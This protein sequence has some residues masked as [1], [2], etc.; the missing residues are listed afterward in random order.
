MAADGS[1]VMNVYYDRKTF[2]LTFRTGNNGSTVAT[3]TDKWGAS[4]YKKFDAAPFNTTYEGRAWQCT[5][6]N[7]YGFALQTLDIMPKFN[8]TFNLYN[9]SS[10]TLKTIYY[11]VENVGANV[12][13]NSWPNNTNNFTLLKEVQ[14]YFNYATYQEEYHEMVGFIRYSSNTAGFNSSS[15]KDFSNNKLNL[16]YLRDSFVLDFNNGED[17]TRTETVE[18]EANLGTYS[19]Y[20]P[21]VPERYEPGSVKFDGW[22]LNPQCTG[23]EYILSEHNMD[24]A[25]LI[26]YAKWTPVTHEVRFFADETTDRT[27]ANVYTPVVDGQAVPF[28]KDI[29][30]GSTIQGS[31]IPPDPTKGQ[32]IFVGWFYE[33]ANGNEQMWDFANTTV[34]GDTD[35][36]AKWSSNTLVEY[37][38]KFVTIE[39]GKE[40]EIADR[41]IGSA[42]GGNSK[43]FDAKGNNQLYDGYREGYFPTTK[44]HTIVMDLENPENNSFTFYYEKKDA[45]P[46]TVY[47][48]TTK[49]E[50]SLKPVEING[51]TYYIV[52][53]TKTVSDNKKAI[54][55]ET[56]KKVA[57]YL[58]DTYQQTLTIDPDGNNIIIFKYNKDEKNGMYV[59]HYMTENIDGE[60]IEH[61]I[62]EGRGEKGSNVDAVIK[63][64][65]NF[66]YNA[67]HKDNVLSG[68]IS[69]EEVLELY[70]YYDRN[71]YPYKV[72]YLEEGTNKPLADD[73]LVSNKVWEEYVTEKAITID[74]YTIVGD[75]TK[76]IQIRKD[77]E[78]PTVNIITF[79]YAENKA[80]LTIKKS[81]P[82]DADYSI[83]E[84]Q[85]F[86]FTVK[87]VDEL[88]NEKAKDIE[89][90]V[91]IHGAGEVKITD[92]PAGKYIVTENEDWSWRYD[93]DANSKEVTLAPGQKTGLV[94]FTNTREKI[95]WLDGDHFLVNIFDGKT[96]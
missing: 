81:Y 59:V 30:H 44:S 22:Y 65:D 49:Q 75:D 31:N 23:N 34:V 7:K 29:Q 89:L 14:T 87:G 46:Y 84:H 28:I 82:K 18:F 35:I 50:G 8:A 93:A 39:N 67:G 90:S 62:F 92:L 56:Y 5:D 68:E 36:Y 57:G 86:I 40:V 19:T 78:N 58:P 17:V 13:H 91:T 70:V 32:Y 21:P 66:T 47:Y 1:T 43:T 71:E 16:Y 63:D 79:Y 37:T 76:S 61:S 4:I 45:V 51:V 83:D 2:T 48:V 77:T 55:T 85:T 54:V 64:I 96:N 69:V 10:T 26:L 73:K 33:D 20:V 12:S 9:Q 24:A 38:V 15:R 80:A 88:G 6:T 94:E 25:N 27:D 95:Y 53:D 60:Y 11:Y 52:A 42:L 72:Q 41:I 74:G 3:I